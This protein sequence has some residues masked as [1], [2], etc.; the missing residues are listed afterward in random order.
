MQMLE[1]PSCQRIVG[2]RRVIGF[3]TGVMVV[4]TFLF[5]LLWLA[6]PLMF[7]AMVLTWL[8]GWP[9]VIM[10]RPA[11]CVI[12]GTTRGTAVVATLKRDPKN[13]LLGLAGFAAMFLVI[14]LIGTITGVDRSTNDTQAPIVDAYQATPK[15]STAV[16]EDSIYPSR[17][18]DQKAHNDA[19]AYTR[20]AGFSTYTNGRFG[21]KI[22]YPSSFTVK[23]TPVNGDGVMLVS[24]DGAAS[25]VASGSNS[26][27]AAR[28]YYALS[29]ASISGELG[30]HK[31][32]GSWFVVTWRSG[33]T[34][35]YRKTFVGTVSQNSFT[36]TCPES[37]KLQYDAG[38]TAMEKS[39]RHGQLDQAW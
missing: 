37:Q 19:F 7:V 34:L 13:T 35:V 12:C 21:F 8:I 18:R 10:M 28:E 9:S 23:E 33:D 15:H 29:L 17:D 31:L 16:S 30:Y 22:D 4:V 26:G 27:G 25:L 32:G 38:I 6:V 3:G 2:F 14:W 1:C 24:P 5:C 20:V 11:R 39:F 36:F